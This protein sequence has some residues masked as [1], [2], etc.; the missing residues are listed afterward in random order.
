MLFLKFE[1]ICASFLFAMNQSW[2]FKLQGAKLR[3]DVTWNMPK[4]HAKSKSLVNTHLR[5]SRARDSQ[6]TKSKVAGI[7]LR[8]VSISAF[9]VT[10]TLRDKQNLFAVNHNV[11]M[12]SQVKTEAQCSNL[13]WMTQAEMTWQ[14]ILH[15]DCLIET[16]TDYESQCRMTDVELYQEKIIIFEVLLIFLISL[17]LCVQQ[18][19]FLGVFFKAEC[20]CFTDKEIANTNKPGVKVIILKIFI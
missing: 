13:L 1:F 5:D 9:T 12:R 16:H 17:H 18:T 10:Q 14:D 19:V 6:N 4:S 11:R 20:L 15:T 2:H 3:D 7:I 8:I